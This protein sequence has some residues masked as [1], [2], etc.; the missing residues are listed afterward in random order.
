M[1]LTSSV[2]EL[3][4]QIIDGT[5]AETMDTSIS[6]PG[7][8]PVLPTPQHHHF[9]SQLKIHHDFFFFF[10]SLLDPRGGSLSPTHV[11]VLHLLLVDF[12]V[13]QPTV[14]IETS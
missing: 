10:F 4:A 1:V 14:F 5:E 6:Y 9:R 3:M 13:S 11:V 2:Y 7:L 8:Q 12:F